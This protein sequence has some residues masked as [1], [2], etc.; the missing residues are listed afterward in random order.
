MNEGPRAL[1]AEKR[2]DRT[3]HNERT[4]E[5]HV[6]HMRPVRP[7]HL[8]EDDIAQYACVVDENVDATEGI[9]RRFD[10]GFRV[11]CFRY[12]ERRSD[13]LTSG[14]LDRLNDIL[15]RTRIGTVALQAGADIADHHARAFLGEQHGNAASNPTP[16]TGND[17]GF[18]FDD[19]RHA[20]SNPEIKPVRPRES[21]DPLL[22]YSAGFP[23]ARE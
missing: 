12:R 8:V 13:C 11:F 7:T 14:F 16:S 6:D 2:R 1:V 17:C 23:L 18:A 10:D 19:V 5:V 9:E 3:T 4:V 15:R 21:G 22:S 20:K